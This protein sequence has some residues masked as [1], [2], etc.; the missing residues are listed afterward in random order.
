MGERWS[1]GGVAAARQDVLYAIGLENGPARTA[2]LLARDD[3]FDDEASSTSDG[4]DDVDV[5][6]LASPREDRAPS[7][8]LFDD[9]AAT[10]PRAAA[11]AAA[12]SSSGS[13]SGRAALG[14]PVGAFRFSA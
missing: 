6:E 1:V 9:R 12:P 13:S 10:P 2:E 11:A 5:A 3:A 14:V 4:G 7:P 8:P